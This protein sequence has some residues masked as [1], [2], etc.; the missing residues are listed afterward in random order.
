MKHVFVVNPHAGSHDS[1]TSITQMVEAY[2]AAHPQFQYLIYHTQCPGDATQWVRQYCSDNSQEMKRFYACGGDGT[3][4]EVLTGLMNQPNSQLSCMASGS[5]ND[6]IKYYGSHDDFNDLARLVDGTEYPVD[7]M[8]VDT[9]N[10]GIRYSINVCNFGFDAEV[11]RHMERVR[12]YPVVGG[13]N[14]YTTGIVLGL[15][16]GM[17]TPINMKADGKPFYEGN[18]LLCALGNGRNYG[19]NYCCAP[20]AQ[21]DDGLIEIGLFRPMS[22]FTL[23]RLIGSYTD[24]SH[25]QRPEALRYIRQGQAREIDLSSSKPFWLSV[26]GELIQGTQFHIRNQQ[27]A[28]TFVAPQRR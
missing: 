2:A 28:I 1:T 6:F 8:E 16:G 23:A 5:G 25:L 24:G 14:A 15:F 17:R 3:L 26:D 10:S 13:S 11:V 18:M 4:N 22:V 9:P 20:H 7:V 19:G 27:Q 12:R 21:N